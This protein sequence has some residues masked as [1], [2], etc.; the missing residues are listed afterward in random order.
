MISDTHSIAE[1]VDLY[2]E[3]RVRSF[4]S[5][6]RPTSP[7]YDSLWGE[8]ESFARTI[9]KRH[10]NAGAADALF[11][12]EVEYLRLLLEKVPDPTREPF[13]FWTLIEHKI[14]VEIA[15]KTLGYDMPVVLLDTISDLSINAFALRMVDSG[16]QA[17]V[18]D[19]YLHH[20]LCLTVDVVLEAWQHLPRHL[21]NFDPIPDSLAV[22]LAVDRNPKVHE[23]FCRILLEL[24]LRH[25]L[26]AS[27]AHATARLGP[28]VHRII[29]QQAAQI[30]LLGHEYGHFV[31][32]HFAGKQTPDYGINIFELANGKRV[33]QFEDEKRR[34]NDE[35]HADEMGASLLFETA[36][37]RKWDVDVAFAGLEIFLSCREHLEHAKHILS[38]GST[39]IPPSPTHPP[40]Y[41]RCEVLRQHVKRTMA[42]EVAD[43]ANRVG[44]LVECLVKVLFEKALPY[45]VAEHIRREQ[46]PKN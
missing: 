15:A 2:R 34:W 1:S 4:P 33:E 14:A 13:T 41:T 45:L 43:M 46:R 44:M 29:L 31:G 17:I 40:A 39:D 32:D 27:A 30:F 37:T 19:P 9:F 23:Q 36:R 6:I 7:L 28:N 20:F 8:A 3:W 11:E 22:Q 26:E 38:I 10:N 5:S 21:L 42:Q 24:L 25:N 35:C 18:L 12:K 16:H